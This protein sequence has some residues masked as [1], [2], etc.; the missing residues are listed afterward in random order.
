MIKIPLKLRKSVSVGLKTF[1]PIIQNLK[2][3]GNSTTEDDSRII[4]NDMLSDVLGYDKYN[5]LKTEQ[6]EGAG[7]LDYAVKV[8]GSPFSTKKD[9]ID[10]IVEAKAIHQVLSPKYVDQTLSYCLTTNTPYFILTNVRQWLLYRVVPAKKNNRPETKLIHEVDFTDVNNLETLTEDFC[11]FARSSY[12]AGYWKEAE[13]FQKVTN[14]NDIFT[15]L[16][17]RK[18]L[19]SVV[20]VLRD[21]HDVKVSEEDIKDIIETKIANGKTL[22]INRQL[23]KRLDSEPEKKKAKKEQHQEPAFETTPQPITDISPAKE[24]TTNVQKMEKL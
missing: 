10:F 15:V 7:R 1:T 20:K 17:S 23:L 9:K 11:V 16:L 14:A 2:A 8:I 13:T 5:E 4:L 3:K 12:L 24:I 19:K 21:I 6:R 18:I 22:E